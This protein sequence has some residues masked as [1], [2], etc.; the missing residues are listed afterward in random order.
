MRIIN[1]VAA[2][3]VAKIKLGQ[4]DDVV[5]YFKEQVN[6]ADKRLDDVEQRLQDFRVQNKVIN[7]DEQTRSLAQ[8]KEVRRAQL[9]NMQWRVDVSISTR[10]EEPRRR[11]PSPFAETLL[12]FLPLSSSLKCT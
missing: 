5:E 6:L 3:N 10:C 1:Q 4:S 2:S 12:P 9:E 11:S 7:Y 8:K